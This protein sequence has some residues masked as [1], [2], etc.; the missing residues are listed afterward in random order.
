MAGLSVT[1]ENLYARIDTIARARG[2]APCWIVP[3]RGTWSYEDLRA[4]AE[5]L[6]ARLGAFGLHPGA[7]VLSQV[8][9][10]PEALLLYL[11]CLRTGVVFVP[12]NTA[13][14]PAEVEYAAADC[15]PGLMV[16][17]PRAEPD[18]K[19]I[20]ASI[21]G[22]MV[23][24]LDAHGAGSLV[25]GAGAQFIPGTTPAGPEVRAAAA[26]IDGAAV[27]RNLAAILYTSGTTGRPKGAMLSHGNLASNALALVELWRFTATDLLIHAL[28]VY[29]VHGLFVATHCALLAGAAAVLLPKFDLDAVIDWLPRA[30]VFMGVPTHYTRLLADPRFDRARAAHMR[31]F[32]SGSAPLLPDT[33]A[34]FEARTGHRI[35][36]RYGMTEA[37]MIASNPHDGERVAGTVGFPLPGFEVRVADAQGTDLPRGT[38]GVLEIRG[39]GLFQGYWRQPE[40]TANEF[41]AD[42]FFITGDIATLDETGRIAIVGRAR[43]LIISGGLNVYPREIEMEIDA[44]AGVSE[45]AVI[46]VPHPDLGEGV[47]AVVTRFPGTELSEQQLLE[48]LRTRLARYKQPRRVIFVAELPRNA[49]GKVQKAVLREQFADVF[50][51]R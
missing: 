38:P 31:L 18:F 33:F 43:D 23:A 37:G 26:A 12:L 24:T 15:T 28:P 25:A 27:E 29:H 1:R 40:R 45:S 34:E 21:G 14:T 8:E 13:C 2:A 42:G 49:M 4:G 10:S 5:G 3:G 9:K 20:A 6:A 51:T 11:A 36:E 7:R 16:C 44:L 30:S 39:P 22:A 17:D 32:V 35:L 48:G 47:L 19:G 50:T 41:R 46:G